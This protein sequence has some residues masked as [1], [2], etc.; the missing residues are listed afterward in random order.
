M[1]VVVLTLE[2]HEVLRCAV[3]P[4]FAHSVDQSESA[5]LCRIGRELL[6]GS[7][8]ERTDGMFISRMM[9]ADIASLGGASLHKMFA[10][11]EHHL[12]ELVARILK[13]M[14]QH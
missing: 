5:E 14:E 7:E 4:F 10:H 3:K 9:G 11:V 6:V 12:G 13:R 2:L 8:D 1:G